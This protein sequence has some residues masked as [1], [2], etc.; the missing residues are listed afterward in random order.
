MSFDDIMFGQRSVPSW[1]FNAKEGPAYVGPDHT[2]RMKVTKFDSMHGREFV[3]NPKTGKQE[4]GDLRWW[5]DGRPQAAPEAPEVVN[6]GVRGPARP[7]LLP[8]L[9]GETAFRAWEGVSNKPDG[10]D[11]GLRRV[12]CKGRG[13]PKDGSPQL[14]LQFVVKQALKAA[15]VRT[16]QASIDQGIWV[17]ITCTG[18]GK[19][20][21]QNNPPKHFT[22]RFW[23]NGDQPDWAADV[24]AQAPAPDAEKETADPWA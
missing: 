10:E 9:E 23:A 22:A 12:V 6:R 13:K 14:D 15:K 17:E 8:V 3:F 21:G 1:T 19:P 16:D 5:V 2:V 4:Q 18:S 11:D 20:M 24:P 7:Y